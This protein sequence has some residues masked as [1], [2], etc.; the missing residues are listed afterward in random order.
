MAGNVK[1]RMD[2]GIQ[3]YLFP[4]DVKIIWRDELNFSILHIKMA[5]GGPRMVSMIVLSGMCD[6]LKDDSK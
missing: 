3:L 6:H 2:C 4:S 5:E 1:L